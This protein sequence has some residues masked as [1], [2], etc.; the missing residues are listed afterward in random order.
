MSTAEPATRAVSRAEKFAIRR[1]PSNAP[2]AMKVLL[3]AGRPTKPKLP[4]ER[5]ALAGS[6]VEGSGG[7]YIRPERHGDHMTLVGDGP[8]D[9]CQDAAVNAATLI[10]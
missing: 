6:L 8:V 7:G 2:T 5:L 10:G 4:A 3:L 9:T 1:L